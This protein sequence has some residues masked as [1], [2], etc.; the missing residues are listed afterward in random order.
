VYILS[1]VVTHRLLNGIKKY[2]LQPVEYFQLNFHGI[3][4]LREMIDVVSK[5]ITVTGSG[6]DPGMGKVGKRFSCHH[7]L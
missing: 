7:W 6:F 5:Y 3:V 4:N 2:V 1:P